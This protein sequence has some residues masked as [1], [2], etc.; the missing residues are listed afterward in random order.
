[1]TAKKNTWYE[2]QIKFISTAK[3]YR[4]F[5][6]QKGLSEG[7][8][9]FT[10]LIFWE[11]LAYTENSMTLEHQR[12]IGGNKFY[13]VKTDPKLRN[14]A[15]AATPALTLLLMLIL[16]LLLITYFVKCWHQTWNCPTARSVSAGNAIDSYIEIFNGKLVSINVCNFLILLPT[17]S[18]LLIRSYATNITCQL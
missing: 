8:R 2:F 14:F 6:V 13:V 17:N 12:K 5:A 10:L 3:N 18:E 11:S 15:A 7:V 1:M 4:M 9:Y 16:I